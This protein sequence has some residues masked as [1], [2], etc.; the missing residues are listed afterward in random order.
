NSER[1]ATVLQ[2]LAE[3]VAHCA[4]LLSPI[5]PDDTTKLSAQLNLPHLA[6]IE[7]SDLHWGLLPEGHM[8]GKPKPAFPRIVVGEKAAE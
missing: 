4:V 7:L 2:H 5:L 6:D 1:L 8:I 3:S